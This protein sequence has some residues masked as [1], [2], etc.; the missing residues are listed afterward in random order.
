MDVMDLAWV[1]ADEVSDLVTRRMR[2]DGVSAGELARRAGERFGHEPEHFARTWRATQAS[3]GVIRLERADELLVLMHQH[4]TDLPTYRA[5]LRGELAADRWPRRGRRRPRPDDGDIRDGG[6]VL[7]D[8]R[9]H[10]RPPR[11]RAPR[12]RADRG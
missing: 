4:L 12:A 2:A 11:S 5:A 6:D 9:P 8:S 3:D 10:R 7:S 1:W